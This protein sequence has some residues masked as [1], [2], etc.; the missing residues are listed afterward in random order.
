MGNDVRSVAMERLNAFIGNWRMEASFP[1]APPAEAVSSDDDAV[2][3]VF[4]WALGGQFV[5]QRSTASQPAPDSL[6][7]IRFD[8]DS[9]TYSQHYSTR[10]ASSACMR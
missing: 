4:E 8:P 5:I 1:L 10:E 2:S 7:I 3:A 6:A 9:E